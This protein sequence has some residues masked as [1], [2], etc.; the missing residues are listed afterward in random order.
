MVLAVYAIKY[1]VFWL[2]LLFAAYMTYTLLMSMVPF[3]PLKT[4]SNYYHYQAQTEGQFV[5]SSEVLAITK[6]LNVELE[7]R[8][9]VDGDHWVFQNFVGA[10]ERFECFES[11]TY[12]TQ[13]DYTFLHNLIPLAERWRGPISVAVYAPGDDFEQALRSIA[14]LRICETPL[15]RRY[16]TF[17]LFMETAHFPTVLSKVGGLQSQFMIFKRLGSLAEAH[18]FTHVTHSRHNDV[19]NWSPHWSDITV[20][21]LVGH[22]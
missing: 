17:H 2:V 1:G 19:E 6:C 12:T 5:H 10:T 15:I 21:S 9:A 13:A 3:E 7:T 20:T 22:L 14:W 11:I 16:V 8:V 4:Y 18:H